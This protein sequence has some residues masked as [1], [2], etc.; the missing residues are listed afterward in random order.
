MKHRLEAIESQLKEA[1]VAR[2]NRPYKKLERS[3]GLKRGS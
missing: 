2:N 1:E 3:K